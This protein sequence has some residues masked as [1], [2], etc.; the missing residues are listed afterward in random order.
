MCLC[1]R[2]VFS[3]RRP[4]FSTFPE[5]DPDRTDDC[6]LAWPAGLHANNPSEALIDFR[7]LSVCCVCVLAESCLSDLHR[8]ILRIER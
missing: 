8:P 5:P 7:S 2:L 4:P 6:R 3:E 1:V